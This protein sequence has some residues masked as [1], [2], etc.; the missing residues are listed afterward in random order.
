MAVEITPSHF[1]HLYS[2]SPCELRLYLNYKGVEPAPPGAF[3]EVIFRLGQRHEKNHLSSFPSYVD[4]TGKSAEKTLEEFG[5][6][7]PSPKL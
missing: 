3:Q 4:L 1:Y 5:Y 6:E 2:P 7:R